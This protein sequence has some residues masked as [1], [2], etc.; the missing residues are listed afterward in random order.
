MVQNFI[1]QLIIQVSFYYTWE[2]EAQIYTFRQ[3]LQIYW[4][5]LTNHTWKLCG[6]IWAT[7][8]KTEVLH[9]NFSFLRLT[10]RRIAR[11]GGNIRESPSVSVL[12]MNCPPLQ[13]VPWKQ[14]CNIR[15]QSKP[16]SVIPRHKL[17]FSFKE[18]TAHCN[19][20]RAACPS[21]ARLAPVSWWNRLTGLWAGTQPV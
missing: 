10:G 7:R 20:V 13:R 17:L 8:D 1:L 14:R 4:L 16:S 9:T 21:A 5:L 6:N 3:E 19:T 11:M 12:M 15:R 2:S 18:G